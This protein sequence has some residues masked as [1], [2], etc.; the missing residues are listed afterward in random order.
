MFCSP[1]YTETLA[2]NRFL[3]LNV[4]NFEVVVWKGLWGS[5]YSPQ[6]FLTNT[7]GAA[8]PVKI[9]YCSLV[10]DLC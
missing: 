7:P 4:C 9:T 2:Y 8:I 10:I 1:N 3:T 5:L 6:N